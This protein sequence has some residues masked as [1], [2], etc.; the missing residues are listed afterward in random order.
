M[1]KELLASFAVTLS[2]VALTAC[3]YHPGDLD[4]PINRKAAWYS[5]LSGD[6]IRKS[7]S[8]GS[9]DYLRLVY[10]GRWYEQVRVYQVVGVAP[11]TL[12]QRVIGPADLS[13][14]N[15]DLASEA[16]TG[17]TAHNDTALDYYKSLAASVDAAIAATPP[18]V[19]QM[20]A[21]DSFYWVASG[22]RGGKFIFD[23]WQYGS[24]GFDT[25]SFPNQLLA[26][27]HSGISFNAPHEPDS[28]DLS[29]KPMADK[30]RWY[31][32]VYADHVGGAIGF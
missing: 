14:V 10:N 20:L 15:A 8:P 29:N 17:K 31:V 24:P 1:R 2:L 19:D 23:A 22:C 12:N 13:H 26:A 18:Q 21:S 30:Q 9:P 6:D 11:Y 25:L 7:C 16:L 5:F 3:E 4:N 28:L 32:R 27:D